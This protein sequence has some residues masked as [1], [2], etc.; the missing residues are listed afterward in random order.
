MDKIKDKINKNTESVNNFKKIK[1]NT[2]H[3]FFKSTQKF[4]SDGN[5]FFDLD[6]DNSELHI[7]LKKK[8]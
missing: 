7:L 6:G 2:I 3:S 1:C 8:K 5:M 4:D